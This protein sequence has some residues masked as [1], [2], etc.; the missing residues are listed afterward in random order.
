MGKSLIAAI[1]ESEKTV[2][3]L[4]KYLHQV[5]ENSTVQTIISPGKGVLEFVRRSG[6][7]YKPQLVNIKSI[8][9]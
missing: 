9:D 8:R 2:G 4:A 5:F 3:Q 1:K 7:K 6:E